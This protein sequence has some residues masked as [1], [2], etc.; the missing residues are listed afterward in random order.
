MD[1]AK[2]E[3]KLVNPEIVREKT[4]EAGTE[5]PETGTTEPNSENTKAEVEANALKNVT[6]S[7]DVA[8]VGDVELADSKDERSFEILSPKTSPQTDEDTD[9]PRKVLD[10]NEKCETSPDTNLVEN[11]L[12]S[13]SSHQSSPNKDVFSS[14]ASI[15]LSPKAVDCTDGTNVKSLGQANAEVSCDK[16]Y[17]KQV[18]DDAR[19][20]LSE[21]ASTSSWISVDDEIRIRRSKK[22]NFVNDKGSDSDP[23]KSPGVLSTDF[24]M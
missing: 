22:E 15:E 23:A 12:F 18:F 13:S 14:G 5:S 4:A 20:D 16:V 2:Q 6:D 7:P 11:K 10:E 17:L 24:F 1:E 8:S 3:T 19:A 9:S 21:T